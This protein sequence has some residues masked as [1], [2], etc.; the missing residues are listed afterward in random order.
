V[1]RLSLHG[2]IEIHR[3][4]QHV[5]HALQHDRAGFA[6]QPDNPFQPQHAIA[7][8]RQHRFQPALQ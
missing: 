7:T 2:A 8:Q 3:R 1:W 6:L 5:M 4:M